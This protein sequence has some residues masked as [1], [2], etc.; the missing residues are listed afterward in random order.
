MRKKRFSVHGELKHRTIQL[1]H[2]VRSLCNNPTL[3]KRSVHRLQFGIHFACE[4]VGTAL[5]FLQLKC[6]KFVQ[7]SL[8]SFYFGIHFAYNL[9]YIL[10]TNWWGRPSSP[11]KLTHICP[12]FSDKLLL[13]WFLTWVRTNLRGSVSQ[14]QGFGN[15]RF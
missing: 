5:F 9:E 13:Q 15:K 1:L 8:T 10:R 3:I 2:A 4:L 12:G 11:T 7:A 14:F 6:H